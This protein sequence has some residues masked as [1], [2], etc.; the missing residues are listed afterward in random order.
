MRV[1]RVKTYL[2]AI[3]KSY[4]DTIKLVDLGQ[5]WVSR[6]IPIM[7][8]RVRYKSFPLVLSSPL[9]DKTGKRFVENSPQIDDFRIYRNTVLAPTPK[10]W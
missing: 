10:T 9:A 4:A 2:S 1:I 6:A 8:T 5:F 7:K 3:R